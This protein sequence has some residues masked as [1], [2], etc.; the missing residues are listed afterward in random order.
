MSGDGRQ[1]AIRIVRGAPD[2]A[3]LA[4]LAVVLR[5]WVARIAGVPGAEGREVDG[6]G[7]APWPDA[8]GRGQRG[9]SWSAA[10]GPTWR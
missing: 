7:G 10:P 6:A 1:G 5:A 4:A 8:G 3:E 2:D 9:G